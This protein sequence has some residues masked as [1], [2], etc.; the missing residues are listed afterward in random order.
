MRRGAGD[1][2]CTPVEIERMLR[3]GAR[4][5]LDPGEKEVRNPRIVAAFRRIG[6][7]EQTGTGMRAIF[8]NWQRLGRVPPVIGTF[9]NDEARRA[10]FRAPDR[11][12]RI[13]GEL[14]AR[15]RRGGP[16]QQLRG[17]AQPHRVRGPRRDA[18]E[19]PPDAAVADDWD[20]RPTVEGVRYHKG[21][22]GITPQGG[23]EPYYAKR[24]P[25]IDSAQRRGAAL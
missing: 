3:D 24:N 13:Q 19:A 6:L 7:S 4:E 5:P 8:G 9:E 11:R 21:E 12:P 2:R 17:A 25:A 10:H 23:K 22:G 14:P 18:S 20:G 16:V 1:E 15:P